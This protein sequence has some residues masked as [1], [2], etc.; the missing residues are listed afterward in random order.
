MY[1]LVLEVAPDLAL[2]KYI[3]IN[4]NSHAQVLVLGN[5]RSLD[6]KFCPFSRGNIVMGL[7][8]LSFSMRVCKL[9]PS[10][11]YIQILHKHSF[12]MNPRFGA[13]CYF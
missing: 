5:V 1:F 11:T 10:H 3:N 4:E 6:F 8:F 12:P 7:T 2:Y 13:K 9:E